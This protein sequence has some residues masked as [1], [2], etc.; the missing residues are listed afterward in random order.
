[1]E[2]DSDAVTWVSSGPRGCSHFKL[3]RFARQVSRHYDAAMQAGCGLN[4]S[5]YGLLSQLQA[6][7]PVRPAD[8]AEHMSLEP[9]T[10]T[11]NLQFLVAQGWA[12]VGPGADARSRLIHLTPAGQSKR[13]QAREVW[14]AA[15]QAFNRQL[16]EARVVQ[17]HRLLDE[18]A[19]LMSQPRAPF[20]V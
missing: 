13:A 20:G 2:V 4:A 7:A 5:Q 8:L 3:R 12:V 1:M 19:D 11:R 15:Q 16:G 17:L 18:C 6:L 9:S 10:L 14:K